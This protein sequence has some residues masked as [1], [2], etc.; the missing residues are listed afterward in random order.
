MFKHSFTLPEVF[1]VVAVQAATV[2]TSPESAR[3]MDRLA[4]RNPTDL[5]TWLTALTEE[6]KLALSDENRIQTQ[7][8]YGEAVLVD[9]IKHG[10]ARVTI[11]SQPSHKDA[12]GYPGWIPLSQL[13]QV[14]REEWYRPEM[15]AVNQQAAWLEDKN[16][17]KLIKLS[18]MTSLPVHKVKGASFEV[19]TPMGLAYLSVDAASIFPRERGVRQGN[20]NSIAEAGKVFLGLVYL[21]GGMSSFGYDC[22][23]FTYTMHKANGY[24][25]GRDAS[26]QALGG[27]EIPFDQTLPGDLLFFARREGEGRIYHVGIYAGNGNMLHAPSAGKGLELAPL[28]E[29]E[30]ANKFWGAKRYWKAGDD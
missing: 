16:G 13:K 2:W 18:Y 20:G 11:P 21:W 12:R 19:V 5:E 17:E 15:A 4:T 24:Q 29:T 8:L 10:W 9:K 22:S 26:D 7:A 30:Y 25:I 6:E 23:G 14:K 28:A 3:A 27:E 1:H